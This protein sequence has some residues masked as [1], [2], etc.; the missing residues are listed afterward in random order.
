[1]KEELKRNYSTLPRE[2]AKQGGVSVLT[3][4]ELLALILRTGRKDANVLELSEEI[5]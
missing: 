5:L 4:A 1:M 3:D 2:K